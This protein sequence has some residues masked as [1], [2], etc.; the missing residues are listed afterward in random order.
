V[1]LHPQ[2]QPLVDA[3]NRAADELPPIWEQ[4]VEDRRAG[5]LK[6]S[7]IAGDGPALDHVDDDKIADVPVRTYA[8]DGAHGAFVF[9]HGGGHVQGDLDTHD[10]TCRQLAVE[11]GATVIAVDYRLAPEHPFPA[12]F[13]D[14]CAVVAAI[15]A[16]RSRYGGPIVIG[17]DSAGGNLAAAVAIEARNE[18]V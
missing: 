6:L 17:G 16:D 7:L 9:L 10:Q 3:I 18:N 2:I 12:A 13:E 15:A 14:S 11:S 5:Y 1:P 8:N 4:T